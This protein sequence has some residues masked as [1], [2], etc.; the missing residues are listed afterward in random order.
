MPTSWSQSDW[1]QP[2]ELGELEYTNYQNVPDGSFRVGTGITSLVQTGADSRATFTP[3]YR[4]WTEDYLAA[5]VWEGPVINPG[6]TALSMKDTKDRRKLLFPR[7]RYDG[8][9]SSFHEMVGEWFKG[10]KFINERMNGLISEKRRNASVS[11]SPL[12]EQ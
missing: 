2:S 6:N 3:Q 9:R 4:F 8:P 10:A 12:R 5:T 11:R 7:E 1:V